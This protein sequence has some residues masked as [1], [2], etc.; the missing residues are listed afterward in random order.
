MK[1]VLHRVQESYLLGR[2]ESA[3]ELID[4]LEKEL[5]AAAKADQVEELRRLREELHLLR[6]YARDERIVTEWRRGM[7]A[8]I[9]AKA[10]DRQ[11]V[12]ADAKAY[13]E[14]KLF[15]DV[16][17]QVAERYHIGRG[18]PTALSI[19]GRRPAHPV[20]KHS[21]G[22]AT[23]VVERPER[24]EVES[25]WAKATGRLRYQVL[26]GLAIESHLDVQKTTHKNCPTCGGDGV[27]EPARYP[28]R[29]AGQCPACL[30]IAKQRVL[31]Y[32]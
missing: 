29:P 22:D 24:R 20:H 21:Y 4:R 15:A 7:D 3:L 17:R 13:V 1:R 18:D 30:G 27:L 28:D 14:K 11:I 16:E 6:A 9:R 23:W 12:Y 10:M 32:R 19:W 31:I 2:Y 8:T 26:L 25:W 5:V